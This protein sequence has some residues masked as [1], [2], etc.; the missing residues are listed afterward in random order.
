MDAGLEQEVKELQPHRDLKA[1]Q[2]VGYKELFRYLDD[3]YDLDF[4]ISEIQK[5]T[6]RYAKRQITW[7]KNQLSGEPF[8]PE[9]IKGIIAYVN[10]AIS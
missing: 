3:D 1:L 6:R 8:E 9:N 10:K 5:N 7:F 2:S 4:A